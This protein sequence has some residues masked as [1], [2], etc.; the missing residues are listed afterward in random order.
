MDP[1]LLPEDLNPERRLKAA[2][3][4]FPIEQTNPVTGYLTSLYRSGSSA[5]FLGW[6]MLVNGNQAAGYIYIRRP[7]SSPYLGSTRYVVMDVTPELLE[8][9][10]RILQGGEPLQIR[11]YQGAANVDA[12]AFLEHRS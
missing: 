3:N 10:L 11:F 4:A 2:A 1:K 8:P 7:V 6:I 5:D 12:S 9:L